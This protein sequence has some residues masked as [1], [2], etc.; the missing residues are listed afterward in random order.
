MKWD[1]LPDILSGVKKNLVLVG[2][3]N[4]H[5][6]SHFILLIRL[7]WWW[8]DD[9]DDDVDIDDELLLWYGWQTQGV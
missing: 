3:K 6:N 5:Q 2:W 8:Y 4:F 9:D 1:F 7:R